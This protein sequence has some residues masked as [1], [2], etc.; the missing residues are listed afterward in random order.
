MSRTWSSLKSFKRK[1]VGAGEPP[2]DPANPTVNF[3]GERLSNA[4]G[5]C[6]TDPEA[7]LAKK[8]AGKGG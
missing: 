5:Q 2:D 4:T 7:E 6:T 3:H 8:G 1:E